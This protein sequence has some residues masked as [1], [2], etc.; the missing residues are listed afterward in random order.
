MK[1]FIIAAALDVIGTVLLS[2][3][4]IP[5]VST[6]ISSSSHL[7]SPSPF[8]LST[9]LFELTLLSFL[10]FIVSSL[11]LLNVA[12][13]YTKESY[14]DKTNM[15]F[16]NGLTKLEKDEIILEEPW[17]PFLLRT[18]TSPTF[19]LKTISTLSIFL[20][21]TKAFLRLLNGVN[22]EICLPDLH[23]IIFAFIMLTLAAVAQ[24]YIPRFTGNILDA[25]GAEGGGDT[26]DGSVWEVEGFKEN[27]RNLAIAA[28]ACGFF[29]GARGST[30]TVVGGRVNA[31]LRRQ[32]M[33]SL[34]AQDVG[35]FDV[36]KTGD[37]TSRLCS[38]T[39]L[40]GD[41]VTLN[42][43]VFLRSFV[44]AIGVLIFMFLIS[45]ELSLLAFV[46][47]PAITIMSKWYGAYIRR[48]TKLTQKKLADANGIGEAAIGSMPTVKGFGAEK[49]ELSEYDV[50]MD[51]YLQLNN[52]SAFAYL[53]YAAAI[54]SLP[55]LVTALV[56]LYGGMLMQSGQITGGQLVSFLLYLSS[57]SD[58][59][60]M[61]GSIFSS[62]TMAVGAADKV[63][64]LMHR[65]PR[66]KP[67]KENA[68]PDEVKV[69]TLRDRKDGIYPTECRGEVTLSKV[70]MYYPARPNRKVLDGMDF[71]AP[72]GAV[73]ALVGPSGGGKSSVISLIQHLYEATNGTIKIDGSEVHMLAPDYLSKN[74]TVV[75]QEP[76]LY[77][78]SVARNIMFGLEGEDDEPTLEDIKN[79]ARLANAHDFISNLPE[80]YDTEVGER[81][82]QL[83]GGQKQRIAIA[84][85]LVRNPKVLLLDEATSALDAESEALVQ[86]AIDRMLG[87]GG[88]EVGN[89]NMGRSGEGTG[90]TVVVV[91]HR[92]STVRN[93]DKICVVK[94][95]VIVE[96]GRHEE[97]IKKEGGE[98]KNLVARQMSA[99]DKLEGKNK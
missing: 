67:W 66:V 64:E 65:K 31:R 38:D 14:D 93:A 35:F 60:N 11:T 87:R 56:L 77:A 26:F 49:A 97:L 69:T 91:A 74:V 21:F 57:L 94:N 4:I 23:L 86:D 92:L 50:F 33:N 2:C 22:D 6:S 5:S 17:K 72:P 63:F 32:L 51:R 20:V 58:A 98:Y 42:V 62:L 28:V 29:S 47:V 43:N 36:T 30:F 68:N 12:Y 96:S 48:L 76:T 24:V 37:I 40:V 34:M 79:A 52:K 70:E 1:V 83:S 59:F 18:L 8:N 81:G 25:L 45:W 78:R 85:A 19:P 27:V 7:P 95:G 15:K 9:S 84:R 71:V 61:M 10:R 99:N 53:W 89:P 80:G 3:D 73:V 55:Q 54:T 82:V 75:S 88:E 90:M 39:T 16:K 46:S 13:K 41:Q 44:Q